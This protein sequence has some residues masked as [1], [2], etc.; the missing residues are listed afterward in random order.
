MNPVDI[1][2]CMLFA[3]CRAKGVD[4]ETLNTLATKEVRCTIW[5]EATDNLYQLCENFVVKK[6][7]LNAM[8]DIKQEQDK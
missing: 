4:P 6:Y 5:K 1:F 3:T 8:P 2:S 7:A